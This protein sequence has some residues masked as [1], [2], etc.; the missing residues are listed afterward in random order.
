M[1]D[2]AAGAT[3]PHSIRPAGAV[4]TSVLLLSGPISDESRSMQR[5]ALELYDALRDLGTIGIPVALER[6]V[7]PRHFSHLFDSRHTRRLDRAWCRWVT[8]P[9][10]LKRRTA[11]LFH[12]LDQGYAHL[13][14]AL[15]PERT[16]ITCHDLIPLLATRGLIPCAVPARVSRLFQMQV[17]CLERARMIISVS[18]ATK[19]TLEQYTQV[20][21]ERIIV[22][23][24]GVNPTFRAMTHANAA[25]RAA[26][27]LRG[28]GPIVLQVATGARYK[29]TPVLLHAFRQLRSRV[30]GIVLVRIGAP[31]FADE[32]K[33]ARQLGILDSLC[34]LEGV[35]DGILAEWYNAADV[36]VFPSYWEGFGWPPLEAMACGTPVVASDIPAIAEVVGKAGLLVPPHD[37]SAIAAATERVL[38]D[39]ALAAELRQKGF[40]QAAQFTWATTAARIAAIYEELLQP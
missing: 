13:I 10:K 9:R 20:P 21:P 17:A 1:T 3:A 19:T 18:S 5:Y 22:I 37:S 15:D 4:D 29:N 6:P 14:R 8:Y 31:L 39:G 28:A 33:L 11:G 26:A 23:P 35:S 40:Q 32:A 7:P 2:C 25:R 24:N 34:H 30:P 38:T 16:V 36:L 12:I 27:G